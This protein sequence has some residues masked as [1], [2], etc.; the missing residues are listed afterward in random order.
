[1]LGGGGGPLDP[2]AH[3]GQRRSHAQSTVN[4]GH[5]FGETIVAETAAVA[6][7]WL[8][9]RLWLLPTNIVLVIVVQQYA[10]TQVD[11]HAADQGHGGHTK[12]QY[13]QQGQLPFSVDEDRRWKGCQAVFERIVLS[14]LTWSGFCWRSIGLDSRGRNGCLYDFL[15]NL[16]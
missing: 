11:G 10:A 9:A 13:D 5:G 16:H 7:V 3:F 1:M 2:F 15:N 14:K 4:I 12:A 6:A 8:L